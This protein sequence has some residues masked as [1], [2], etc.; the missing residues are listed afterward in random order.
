MSTETPKI[1]KVLVPDR[2]TTV[3]INEAI[4]GPRGFK[5]DKGDKGDTGAQGPQGIQ[6]E[7]GAPGAQGPQGI[8]GLK[9]DTGDQG[10]IGLTGD[11]GATGAQGPQGIQGTQGIQGPKGDTGDQGPIGLAGAQGPQGIQG[12][13]GADGAD[14]APGIQGPQGIQGPAGADG[15][16]GIQGPAGADGAPGAQGPAGAAGAQGPA[17]ADGAPGAAGQG[18]PVGGTAGQ[19]L[20]KSSGTDYDAAWDTPSSGGGGFTSF[21][22]ISGATVLNTSDNGK[23]I[24]WTA[25]SAQT[26]TLPLASALAGMRLRVWTYSATCN[27]SVGSPSLMVGPN[28]SGTASVYLAAGMVHDIVSDGTN[29]VISSIR[30][31]LYTTVDVTTNLTLTGADSGKRYR[32]TSA[33]VTITL[34]AATTTLGVRYTFWAYVVLINLSANQA[35]LGPGG[36]GTTTLAVPVGRMVEIISDGSSWIVL[37]LQQPGSFLS[38]DVGNE[39]VGSIQVRRQLVG[40]TMTAGNSTSGANLTQVYWVGATGTY[41]LNTTST[42]TW[43]NISGVNL[44]NG[45]ASFFQRIA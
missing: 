23:F 15:A 25:T 12:P 43:R 44:S 36:S 39:G 3:K 29:W 10:P 13:A 8:H 22:V 7:T 21:V 24:K 5:G 45:N 17:G 32:A 20:T 6:G 33:P 16:P 31:E 37:N 42:G 34:P 41:T 26:L 18:V 28:G 38:T 27:L 40:G 1:I 19:V 11:T 9:G 2:V 4:P 14:G 30:S 35:I